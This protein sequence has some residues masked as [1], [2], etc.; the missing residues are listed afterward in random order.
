MDISSV[1]YY[2][3]KAARNNP[4]LSI[5]ITQSSLRGHQQKKGSSFPFQARKKGGEL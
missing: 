5:S 4:A 2:L 1:L 3:S